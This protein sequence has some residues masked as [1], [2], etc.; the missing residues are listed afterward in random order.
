MSAFGTISHVDLGRQKIVNRPIDSKTAK[1]YLGGRGLAGKIISDMINPTV[2]PLSPDNPFVIMTGP[3]TGT[4]SP[5]SGRHTVASK[6]PLTGT[7]AD[8]SSGGF[9]GAKMRHAGFSGIVITGKASKPVY[10][11]LNDGH[12]ELRDASPLWGKNVEETEHI[13]KKDCDS[14]VRVLSIGPAGENLVNFASVMNE[15]HRAAG[16]CGLGAVMGSKHLKAIVA[17]GEQEATAV[18]PNRLQEL[19]DEIN[20]RAKA[21][22]SEDKPPNSPLDQLVRELRKYGTAMALNP[23]NELGDLPTAYHKTTHFEEAD[24]ISGETLQENHLVRRKA[25]YNCAI[26]CGRVTQAK[27][28]GS[29]VQTEGPEFETLVALG[30]ICSNSNL[31]SI[32]V[33]NHLCNLYGLDTISTGQAIGF[34]FYLAEKGV[35][36]DNLRFGDANRIVEL[37]EEIAFRK[38]IGALLADG[39]AK[40]SQKLGVEK[41]AVTIKGMEPPAFDPRTLT[42]QGLAYMVSSRGADHRRASTAQVESFG[43]PMALNKFHPRG[44]ATLVANLENMN[45]IVDSAIICGIGMF[46]Y[47]DLESQPSVPEGVLSRMLE[48]A[49]GLVFRMSGFDLITE[50]INAVTGFDYSNKDLRTVAN[51]IITT[52]RLFNT[53]TGFTKADD[54][55]PPRWEQEPISSGP[56]E[57]VQWNEQHG[58]H[59]LRKY[60]GLRGWDSE[61]NPKNKTVDKL[62]LG[63]NIYYSGLK[64]PMPRKS[65][66]WP[67]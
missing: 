61:G 8:S 39:V 29:T 13:L 4:L 47:L 15:V 34:A 10:L 66:Y 6:S 37:V 51:R 41:Y 42:G 52:E 64:T 17:S 16:R 65:L 57:G 20:E 67:F 38:G 36:K 22:L 63:S 44:K 59:M 43:I 18:D 23:A 54:A 24:Q 25:C 19:A 48:W 60:Y 26:A 9:F 3:L 5:Y 21:V 28:N 2:H 33:A 11:F 55:L 40:C 58:Q 56:A 46:F 31:S 45:V 14:Q 12:A 27:W 53:Q 7:L 35:L 62:G 30:S 50:A 32:I 49:P 1:S